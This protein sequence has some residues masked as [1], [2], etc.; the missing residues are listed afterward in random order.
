MVRRCV[1]SRNLVNEEPMAH[2][3][4]S[5]PPPKKKQAN[6]FLLGSQPIIIWSCNK[7]LLTFDR[8]LWSSSM[9]HHEIRPIEDGNFGLNLFLRWCVCVPLSSLL[10]LT[11]GILK[12]ET[13]IHV[14]IHV[15]LFKYK[16]VTLP[17]TGKLS[18]SVY[19]LEQLEHLHF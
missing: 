10:W 19:P 13:C 5:R 14:V 11:D 8:F 3:G 16:T 1:W 15:G 9:N 2:W 4:L 6:K 17:L 7:W 18:I 12:Y